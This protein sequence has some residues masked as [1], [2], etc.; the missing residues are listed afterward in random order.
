MATRGGGEKSVER[1]VKLGKGNCMEGSR[2]ALK[3]LPQTKAKELYGL[4]KNLSLLKKGLEA[5]AWSFEE[6]LERVGFRS[7]LEEE[8]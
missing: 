2:L 3:Q 7:Y 1:I 8:Y 4:M 6:I 5:Y